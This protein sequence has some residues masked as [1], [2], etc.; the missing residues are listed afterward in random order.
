MTPACLSFLA[1]VKKKRHVRPSSP[2]LIS[3][4]QTACDSASISGESSIFDSYSLL[5]VT[6]MSCSIHVKAKSSREGI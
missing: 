4:K 6:I 1:E 2:F 5:F 3:L